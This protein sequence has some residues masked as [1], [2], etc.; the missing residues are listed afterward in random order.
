MEKP[1]ELQKLEE[2][3]SELINDLLATVTVKEELWNYHPD[4]PN[5]KDVV[6]EYD[7]LCQIERDITL[8]IEELS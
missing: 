1:A 3:K 2:Q 8:E 7:I 5:K 4:N 6:K